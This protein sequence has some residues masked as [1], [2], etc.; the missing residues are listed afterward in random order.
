MSFSPSAF[1]TGP[2]KPL[3]RILPM[4]VRTRPDH[5]NTSKLLS[6]WSLPARTPRPRAR[7]PW[8]PPWPPCA[9]ATATAPTAARRA[10][11][12]C[13]STDPAGPALPAREG[14]RGAP[15]S[16]TGGMR[17]KL[18]TYIVNKKARTTYNVKTMSYIVVVELLLLF[19]P[20]PPM[21]VLV[22]LASRNT[23]IRKCS[24]MRAR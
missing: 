12:A 9:S 23:L 15:S 3:A 18:T 14:L 2:I 7:C 19:L 8:R 21:L 1:H 17:A 6:L 5:L 10:R 11:A 22:L 20:L 4:D 24:Q 13:R 16:L